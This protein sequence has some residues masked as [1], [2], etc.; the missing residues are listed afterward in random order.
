MKGGGAKERKNKRRAGDKGNGRRGEKGMFGG[1]N[2]CPCGRVCVRA[3]VKEAAKEK[4][5]RA[6]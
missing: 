6:E 5:E 3:R 1:P 2:L 4:D